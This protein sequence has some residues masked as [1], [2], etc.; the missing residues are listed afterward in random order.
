MQDFYEVLEIDKS[1]SQAQIKAAYKR[2]AMRYHPDHNPENKQAEET[3]KLVNEA[4]H[5]LSD[6]EKKLRYDSRF[7]WVTETQDEAYWQEI[8][9]KRFEQWKR[10]QDRDYRLDRNYFKIQGLAFLVFLIMAGFCFGIMNTAKYYVDRK[11]QQKY[12]ANSQLLKQVNGLFVEDR[13]DDA[14]SMISVLEEKDPLEYRFIFARDSLVAA[15]RQRADGEFRQNN[16]S[17]AVKHYAVLQNYEH[18]VRFETLE[19]M[20]LCQ[21]YLGNYKESLQAL[22]HL[23]NQQPNNLNLIYQIAHTNLEKLE[24]PQEAL[25]Y[26]TLGKKLF[27]ENL[28]RVY[29]KAFEIVMD[30]ADAP[31]IYFH[32]FHGR[33]IANIRLK[34][35]KE[36]VT[37]C[38]WA[39]FLRPNEGQPYYFRAVA[40]IRNK[41]L[42]YICE[43]LQHAVERGVNEAD[44][45]QKK[46]C[47]FT[48]VATS[49]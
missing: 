1:A 17:E 9:R 13:F 20:S 36:A 23:H 40:N 24:N 3:F 42:R 43:D 12:N 25:Q 39:I 49:Q 46:H 10:N 21:Y 37:D 18:P 19:N 15:L 33:A 44:Q 30:P 45:L 32:I 5:T 2:M 14:F 31:D 28:G 22:K 11:H 7:Y 48:K 4:Y 29:G 47:N 6:P 27:K 16:F 34:N 8:K 26:F 35:Y 41:N 38:N